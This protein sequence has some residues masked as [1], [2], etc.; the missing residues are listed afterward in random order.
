[1]KVMHYNLLIVEKNI[2]NQTAKVK[3]ESSNINS[4]DENFC[5]LHRKRNKV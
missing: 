1:M 4:E 3:N 5:H 2:H